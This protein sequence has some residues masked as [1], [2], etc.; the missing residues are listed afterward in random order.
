MSLSTIYKLNS[1]K[2]LCKSKSVKKCKLIKGCKFTNGKTR[3]INK[4]S[5]E[6]IRKYLL[7]PVQL[8]NDNNVL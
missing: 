3:K 5:L 7:P 4:T 8:S 6:N 1:K 2:S